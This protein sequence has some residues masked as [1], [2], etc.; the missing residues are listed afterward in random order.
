MYGLYVKVRRTQSKDNVKTGTVIN[1][2][3]VHVGTSVEVTM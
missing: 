3:R 1:E 2:S